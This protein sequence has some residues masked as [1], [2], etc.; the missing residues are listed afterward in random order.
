MKNSMKTSGKIL[1]LL[2][3]SFF[4]FTACNQEPKTIEI[5]SESSNE[6]VIAENNQQVD[7]KV[8]GMV[9]AMGC[10]KF[11]EDKVANLDG[12]V[13]S[14]VN[15]EEGTAHFE[16]DEGLLSS[17][18]IE[19]F[20]NEIHDGQ[21]KATIAEASAMKDAEVMEEEEIEEM[22]EGSSETESL[23]SVSER[24]DFSFP[25]IFTYFLKRLR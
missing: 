5:A 17:E 13:I 25:E 10:A 9:C 8:E 3:L 15:F 4:F 11:I 16:F 21:Y 7:M 23:G 18:D 6:K 14:N 2:L 20:I 19:D 24:I 12:I 22:E 1:T